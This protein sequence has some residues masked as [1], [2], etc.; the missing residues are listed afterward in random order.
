MPI[1]RD[2]FYSMLGIARRAGVLTLGVD[3]VLSAIAAGAAAAVFLDAGASDNTKKKLRDCC[4]FY[5]TALF[6]T[7]PDRLGQAIGKPG[8]MCVAVA[9]G[10]L[11]DKLAA[12]AQQ[13]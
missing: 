1:E 8:R 12:L 10:T 7:V 2:A 9:K 5:G 4:A 3:G 13:G 11:G 6:E